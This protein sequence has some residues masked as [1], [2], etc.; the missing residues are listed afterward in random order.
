[1]AKKMAVFSGLLICA[2]LLLGCAGGS[3][4]GKVCSK[5]LSD[6]YYGTVRDMTT[7]AVRGGS[8]SEYFERQ[9]KEI[10]AESAKEGCSF[11]E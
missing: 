2:Q 9:L 11:E 10:L 6:R 8:R 7:D 5:S 1:M 3:S 4:G